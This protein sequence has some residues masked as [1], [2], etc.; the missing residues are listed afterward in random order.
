MCFRISN[1]NKKE[2][3][4]TVS[5]KCIVNVLFFL[6]IFCYT[7]TLVAQ[8]NFEGIYIKGNVQI[9]G[10]QFIYHKESEISKKA[11]IYVTENTFISGLNTANNIQIIILKENK[12]QVFVSNIFPKKSKKNI[13]KLKTTFK[14]KITAIP[15]EN[16]PFEH[17]NSFTFYAIAF[18]STHKKKKSSLQKTVSI[19]NASLFNK[20]EIALPKEKLSYSFL[21]E[22]PYN[23]QTTSQHGTRPPPTV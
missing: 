20:A 9:K 16:T 6:L 11:T 7:N 13:T 8:N 5:M 17:N 21:K 18:S 14:H 19:T 3:Q 23:L 12:L 1:K 4:F 15:F 10:T 22:K 2:E